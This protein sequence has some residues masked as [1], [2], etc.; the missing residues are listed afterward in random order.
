MSEHKPISGMRLKFFP[1]LALYICAFLLATYSA[2][3]GLII[4]LKSVGMYFFSLVSM[5]Y[6]LVLLI[7]LLLR[8]LLLDITA[9]L[10]YR[11][12]FGIFLLHLLFFGM[13][14]SLF[15]NSNLSVGLSVLNIPLLF[16]L[17]RPHNFVILYLN[18]IMLFLLGLYFTRTT[19]WFGI[20]LFMIIL[21]VT[22]IVDYFAF[23]IERYRDVIASFDASSFLQPIIGAVVFVVVVGTIL[24]VATPRFDS[25]DISSI[26]LISYDVTEEREIKKVTQNDIVEMVISIFILIMMVFMLLA[27]LNYINKKLRGGKKGLPVTMSP[28]SVSHFKKVLKEALTRTFHIDLDDPR[29]AIIYYYNLFCDE[30][31]RLGFQRKPYVTPLDYESYL[32][33]AFTRD[34][35]AFE[36]LRQ[37]FER[38]KYS[39]EPDSSLN[40]TS[41][42]E[43]TMECIERTKE[44]LA[45][46]EEDKNKESASSTDS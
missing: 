9:G 21:V 28:S 38:A 24:F 32:S 17:L 41:Y 27:L 42:K 8:P 37:E 22:F 31:G 30:M 7:V 23:R 3:F 33:G 26:T 5:T 36:Y 43:Q 34:E 6:L 4:S 2:G 10:Q 19:P 11:E 35:D 18:S 39:L 20:S 14:M 29:S 45:R 40:A 25:T 12:R 15:E 1:L 13:S 16:F 44:H 46:Y